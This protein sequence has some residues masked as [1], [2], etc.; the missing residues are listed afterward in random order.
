[1]CALVTGVQ[2]CALPISMSAPWPERSAVSADAMSSTWATLAP[3]SSASLPAVT[4]CPSSVPT[5]RSRMPSLQ[6]PKVKSGT[7]LLVE[8][9]HPTIG[10]QNGV[11]HHLEAA[12]VLLPTDR[13]GTDGV[14]LAHHRFDVGVAL[15]LAGQRVKHNV[16]EL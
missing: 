10:R 5:M 13:G 15:E 11:Q 9:R 16:G 12:R 4:M 6:V 8:E 1:M 14:D 3:L 7:F 2:T